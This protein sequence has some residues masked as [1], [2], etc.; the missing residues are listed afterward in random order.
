VRDRTDAADALGN[1]LGIQRVSALEDSFNASEHFAFTAGLRDFET[2]G[3]AVWFDLGMNSQM[4]LNPCQWT[5]RNRLGHRDLLKR[6]NFLAFLLK[7][8]S[9]EKRKHSL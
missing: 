6:L 1:L 8:I 3:G 7:W 5:N 2:A 9:A 4:S